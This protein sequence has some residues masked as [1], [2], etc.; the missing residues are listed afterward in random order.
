MIFECVQMLEPFLAQIALDTLIDIR[1]HHL[2]V[3]FIRFGAFE[4]TCTNIANGRIAIVMHLFDVHTQIGGHHKT[5]FAIVFGTS[6]RSFLFQCMLH[7]QM[8]VQQMLFRK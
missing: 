1:V 3:P 6:E 2:V 7:F 4:K 8:R 5:L